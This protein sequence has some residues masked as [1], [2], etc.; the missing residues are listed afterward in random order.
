MGCNYI[1]KFN[2]CETPHLDYYVLRCVQDKQS[3]ILLITNFGG[4]I[5]GIQNNHCY[6]TSF[7]DW[8]DPVFI[9]WI[10]SFSHRVTCEPD[11]H[12]NFRWRSLI[13]IKLTFF[14]SRER[15][16]SIYVSKLRL[17]KKWGG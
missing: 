10:V 14:V 6:K 9:G 3:S 5:S 8:K 13:D 15:R 16:G 2:Q 4:T 1:L 12:W 17:R 11:Y 7:R